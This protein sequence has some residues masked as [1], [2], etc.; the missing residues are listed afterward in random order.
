MSC[1]N[2]HALEFEYDFA[3]TRK[4]LPPFKVTQSHWNQHGSIGDLWYG[5]VWFNVP[6][7]TA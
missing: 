5:M 6:L 4:G 1:F 2:N 3:S 7:D